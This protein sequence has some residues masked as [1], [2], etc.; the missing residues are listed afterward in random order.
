ME[1]EFHYVKGGW[2][3]FAKFFIMSFYYGANSTYHTSDTNISSLPSFS[4][5]EGKHISTLAE[6]F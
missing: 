3:I 6:G 5:S 4:I 2:K 1:Q